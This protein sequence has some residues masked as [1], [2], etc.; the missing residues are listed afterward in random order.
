MSS[1]PLSTLLQFSCNST[2]LD[3]CQTCAIYTLSTLTLRQSEY[4]MGV[5]IYGG[6]NM[7]GVLKFNS[8]GDNNLVPKMGL[9]AQYIILS[10]LYIKVGL[11]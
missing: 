11:E 10:I 7:S 9:V 6:V 8:F 3:L 1:D 4:V 5:E 2:C